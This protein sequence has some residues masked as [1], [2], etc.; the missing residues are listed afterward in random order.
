MGLDESFWKGR[1]V[2]VT[3]GT[4]LLGYQVVRCLLGLGAKVRVL[5]LPAKSRHPLVGETGVEL[6]AGDVRDL[7]VVRVAVAACDVVFHVAGVVAVWGPALGRVHGVHTEGTKNVIE[8]APRSA[9]VVVT[10]SVVTVGASNGL[11]PLDEDSPFGLDHLRID[12]VHAKRAGERIALDQAASGRDVVVVNPGYLVGPDDFERS[13]MGRFCVRYWRGMIPFA[14]PGGF[15][16]V[17]V[18]D[19]ARGH[20]LAAQHGKSGRRYILGG[21]NRTHAAFMAELAG[22]SGLNPRG[23]PVLPY[24]AFAALAGLGECRAWVTRRHPYPSLQ[25]ARLNRYH[26]FYRS[27]RAVEELGYVSRPVS[28]SL[29]DSFDWHAARKLI[30]PQ[31][32]GRW[33]MRPAP[34]LD[35]ARLGF[36]QP[37]GEKVRSKGDSTRASASPPP[38]SVSERE[39][40]P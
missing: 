26:W 23:T 17:D 38:H 32:A 10:S 30:R 4:G 37:F 12:Y 5:A 19:V 39:R 15:N 28:V 40:E 16:L 21:E 1:T 34:R 18:R 7:A 9:R 33:W 3:G 11:E 31:G 29:A 25:H 14:P 8:A 13:V 27:T 24:W 35:P 2:C 36:P 20:L 6:I 22:V